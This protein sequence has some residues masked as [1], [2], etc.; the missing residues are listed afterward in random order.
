[1]KFINCA[2][3]NWDKLLYRIKQKNLIPV[4]GP[5]LYYIEPKRK[6]RILLYD[7][8]AQQLAKQYGITI[9]AASNHK[10]TF[11]CSR[12]LE[13][14]NFDYLKLSESI[15][16]ILKGIL[17]F[18]FGPIEKLA[19]IKNLNMFITTTYDDFLGDTIKKARNHPIDVRGYTVH[20]KGFFHSED[21]L[22]NNIDNCQH[23]LVYH[24]LGHLEENVNP[25]YTKADILR[26]T[27]E[28]SSDV[29]K[30]FQNKLLRK[31][32]NSTLLFIGF[33]Q[34]DW[35]LQN[36]IP[37][38]ANKLKRSSRDSTALFIGGIS[39][40]DDNIHIDES[41][42]FLTGYDVEII[43]SCEPE[44]FVDSLFKKLEEQCPEIIIPIPPPEIVKRGKKAVE[45]YS[46]S[47][48]EGE[49]T[50][51]QEVKILLVGDGGVGKTSLANQL[52]YQSF[53]ENESRTEGINIKNWIVERPRM[54][55]KVHVWDFGGQEI[56]HAT[57]Q[58]FFSKRSLYILVLDSRKEEITEYWLKHIESFGGD[59]PV[60]VV[61][62]KID[63]NPGLFLNRKSLRNK[64]K[65]IKSFHRLSCKTGEGISHF[66]RSLEDALEHLEIIK[67]P[68]PGN[69]F[70]VK[71]KLEEEKD[72]KR[73]FISYKEYQDICAEQNIRSES[74]QRT[75]LDFLNDLG[76]VL[77][78]QVVESDDT[79]V[80][81]PGWVTEAVYKIINS[82]DLAKN[83]G[84]IK[85]NLL[86][87]ILKQKNDGDYYYPPGKYIYIIQLMKK[88]E[89]CFEIDTE[90]VLIPDL[91]DVEESPFEFDYKSSLNFI[92]KYD[93][94]PKSIMPR[95]IVKMNLDIKG[96]LPWRTGVVLEDKTLQ[97]I[98]VIKVDERERK[99]FIYLNGKQKKF[100]LAILRKAFRDIHH[101]F[102][103]LA[104]S[105]RVPVP[106][107]LE[108]TI[109]YDHLT[110]MKEA[111]KKTYF[112]E[113]A[114]K[115]YD[116]DT[117]LDGYKEKWS[118]SVSFRIKRRVAILN[119][120]D[121]LISKKSTLESTI[122]KILEHNLWIL[123]NAYSRMSSNKTL[124]N[125][126]KD[127]LG[128]KYEGDNESD[129]PD[130]LLSEDIHQSYLL[131]ELKRPSHI[132]NSDD[133][134]QAV[135]YRNKLHHYFH[136]KKI[137]IIL[138]GGKI[139]NDISSLYSR[140]EVKY[141]SYKDVL[142]NARTNLDWL[143]KDLDLPPND[144]NE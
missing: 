31:M 122:H 86:D 131:I 84:I 54:E 16:R 73:L 42:S 70:N 75:L 118:S 133:E 23:S 24:I 140:D 44:T 47:L 60:L 5:G 61:L 77:F 81:D 10:F 62:N 123:G 8:I 78:Y 113:G 6:E 90:H 48:R 34:D 28:F 126:V 94:L 143:L 124:K 65:N 17:L 79:H 109:G 9:P 119:E 64:Y 51:L 101:S 96:I 21:E 100:Y 63:E 36:F 30:Y 26:S 120:L 125:A 4:I 110:T 27:H 134:N 87:E 95:F 3:F 142:S 18:P 57:H 83:K 68:W 29:D 76:V 45:D 108:A 141:L 139:S 58:F 132:L 66:I 71:D 20:E 41:L 88:F 49:F 102:E 50:T 117:L 130:L 37:P 52:L 39:S 13:S 103:K 2:E 40:A 137:N 67:T 35:F 93:F 11:V 55:I 114:K 22:Y 104:V 121:N 98:A 91:L 89:I 136:G 105:E 59:S 92:L 12:I 14:G 80:L 128:R 25:A 115:E 43:Y 116:I 138:I 72:K 112:P 38:Y 1:M 85:L 82:K 69:W 135:K 107:N 99:I 111:G 56:M 144:E 97:S 53:N 74:Y 33:R 127:C 106:D 32:R 129:R 7:F 46:S 15:K 19:H